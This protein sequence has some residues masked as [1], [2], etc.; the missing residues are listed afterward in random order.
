MAEYFPFF[1]KFYIIYIECFQYILKPNK[2]FGETIKYL[3]W[4][5][6]GW[7]KGYDDDYLQNQ[8]K[9]KNKLCFVILEKDQK[10]KS[11]VIIVA[12]SELQ[13]GNFWK[14]KKTTKR[15][16]EK[17][18]KNFFDFFTNQNRYFEKKKF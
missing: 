4:F 9:K 14:K 7:V 13:T 3:S 10:V 2:S 5:T 11:L 12:D 17:N 16:L 1:S 8:E 18:R 6:D 15:I